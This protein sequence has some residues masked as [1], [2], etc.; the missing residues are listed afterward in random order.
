MPLLREPGLVT[1]RVLATMFGPNNA[2]LRTDQWRYI[3]YEDGSEELYDHF[4]DPNEWDNLAGLQRFADRIQ[5]MRK[6]VAPYLTEH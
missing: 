2:S 4:R 3:R 6:A 5:E 1:G